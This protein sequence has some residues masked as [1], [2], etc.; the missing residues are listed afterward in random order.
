MH[1]TTRWTAV[2]AALLAAACSGGGG[3]GGGGGGGATYKVSG[4]VSGATNVTVTLAGAATGTA[5]TD[6]SGNYVFAGLA[7]GTYTL[8]PSKQGY[9]FSPANQSVTVN[10][11]DAT[12]QSFAAAAVPVTHG[13]SGCIMGCAGGGSCGYVE[14]VLSGASSATTRTTS[15]G[16]GS[17]CY[18]FTG[19]ASGSY[20]VTPTSATHAFAPASRSVSL[21][22]AD[23]TGQ[24][25]DATWGI[26]GTVTWSSGAP[27]ASVTVQIPA[28]GLTTVSG[29]NGYYAF[30][31]L[32]SN[33][34]YTVVPS[35]AGYTFSPASAS[36][37]VLGANVTGENFT[38]AT[39]N[40]D[41]M[42]WDYDVWQ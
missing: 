24:D 16:V 27:A 2:A 7:N 35:L 14:V 8:T 20:V 37:Q 42:L 38:A 13:I 5:T 41:A 18:T 9:T 4:N 3:T 22:G 12:A 33:D 36:V 15:T 10:G 30:T 1:G 19:L 29:S 21:A 11:A 25:F 40:W 6:A 31:G 17:G 39:S 26:S 28:L 34:T 23:V 32:L